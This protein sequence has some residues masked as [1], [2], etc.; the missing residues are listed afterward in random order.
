V[1]YVNDSP[2]HVLTVLPNG[3]I[4]ELHNLEE[5][6]KFIRGLVNKY[7]SMC[8]KNHPILS[9]KKKLK[10]IEIAFNIPLDKTGN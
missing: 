7:E 3:E 10:D 5:C 8:T 1:Q 4:A 6:C 2:Q 9:V